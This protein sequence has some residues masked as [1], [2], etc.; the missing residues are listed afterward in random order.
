MLVWLPSVTNLTKLSETT[1]NQ[2]ETTME[3][4]TVKFIFE[5]STKG[6]HRFAECDSD[7]HKAITQ[8]DPECI[9]GTLYLRKKGFGENAPPYIEI[10]ITPVDK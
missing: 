10:T 5:R 7:T 1:F 2:K 9:V 6:A 3:S 4:K 8:S